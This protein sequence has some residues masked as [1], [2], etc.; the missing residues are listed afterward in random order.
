MFI[1]VVKLSFGQS[2][3]IQLKM[4]SLNLNKLDQYGMGKI[5]QM[6]C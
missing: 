6:I 2:T 5:G 1:A 4:T 3:Q